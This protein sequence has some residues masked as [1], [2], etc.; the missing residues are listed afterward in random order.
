MSP[1]PMHC[2][3]SRGLLPFSLVLDLV[4]QAVIVKDEAS[5]FVHANAAACALLNA[6][7][8]ELRGKTDHD[9]L[10]REQ[11]DR[12]RQAD[13]EVLNNGQERTFEEHITLE[14]GTVRSLLTRKQRIVVPGLAT[15]K[16]LVV[17]ISDVTGLRNAEAI[18]QAAEEHHRAF[19]ELHPQTPWT[20]DARG[21][22]TEIGPGWRQ[23]SGMPPQKALGS[24]WENSVH[25]DDLEEIRAKWT[26]SVRQGQPLDVECRISSPSDGK[27]RWFRNRAAP[28]RDEAGHVVQWYGLLEDVHQQKLAM[29]ALRESEELFRGIADSVPVMMWLTDQ[30]G[31]ATYH[32][33]R[34]LE[35]TGQS[36]TDALGDGWSR[37]VHPDDLASVL[38]KF[39][40]DLAN[41]AFVTLEYRLRRSD[42]SWAWVI[43]T[44]APRLSASGELLGYAGSI[45]DITDRRVAELAL[46]ESEA[47]VRSIFDSSPDCIRL[48]DMEGRPLLMNRAGREFLGLSSTDGIE[49]QTWKKIFSEHDMPKLEAALESVRQGGT[50]R[51][52]AGAIDAR[53]N[54]RYL[55]VIAAPVF[56]AGG[57][58]ARTVTIWRDITEAKAAHDDAE[59][60]RREAEDAARQLSAALE[61]TMDCVVA[62]D[63]SWRI[64]YVN[65]NARKFLKLDHEAIG[66]GLLD[67][68]PTELNGPFADHC[69]RALTSGKPVSFE[70]YLPTLGVWLEVHASPTPVGL[71]IFFRDTSAR[72]AAEQERFHAQKQVFHMSRHDVLTGLPNRV[73]FVEAMEEHLRH[74]TANFA[75]ALLT[76]DLDD[77]KAVNDSYG[78]HAGDSLLRQAAERL[79]HC[80]R[81][82][83]F[84]ARLGGDEFAVGLPGLRRP[85]DA[86]EM[87]RRLIAVLSQPFDMDGPS[88]V[89]GASVGISVAPDDGTSAYQITKASDVALYRA[90][91][92][93]R[94]T[95]FRYVEGMDAQ[96][97]ARLALKLSLREAL[98]RGEFE[99]H[100]QTLVSLRSKQVTTCEALLRWRHPDKGLVS[101]ADFI[102]IAEETG[103]IVQIGAWVLQEACRQAASW[104]D[105]ISVAVNLSP[106]QFKSPHLVETVRQAMDTAGLPASRLQLE[107]TESVLLDEDD[108]NLQTLEQIRQLGVKIAMDD[109][110]TGYSS[111]GY[112]RSFPFDKI[113]VDRSFISDLPQGKESLAIVRAVAGIGKSL[114]ITTTVEGI[115]TAEQLEVVNLEGFDEAQGYLF[116]RPL[117]A[118]EVR[119]LISSQRK[120]A[121]RIRES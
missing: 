44:G 64:T 70:E 10:T 90:K 55:D 51:L 86:G 95:Y 6:S 42:G 59:A 74:A 75:L 92:A 97:Q 101:P 5:R 3:P 103:L 30:N 20:A 46:Q 68:F 43:D 58:P 52:E 60:A 9:F 113:K 33:K 18:L 89:I 98:A 54:H 34:W 17:V 22:V 63:R 66:Y 12:L 91:A 85:D 107:I 108:R 116:A 37:A 25:P 24:G 65:Q 109:F 39:A 106:V 87:A 31:R 105:D 38:D 62:I 40:K 80:V 111:L 76:V 118:S 115:E 104:P 35:L 82:T 79:R 117:P 53:G 4:E 112:L 110:G 27:Y 23:V 29:D 56:N 77:F 88:V 7:L 81:D 19:V 102:P 14:N 69:R 8:D 45:L 93:G 21:A 47:S 57:T 49:S 13:L 50:A 72:R 120:T 48:L 41:S 16:L 11:A 15:G 94:G 2:D 36:E 73:A 26:V 78:H 1:S 61:A 119:E 99:V 100:Y 67:L 83:D 114:G 71:S 121:Q 32:S 96:L 28:R 84:V